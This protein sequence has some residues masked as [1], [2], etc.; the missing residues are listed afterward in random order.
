MAGNVVYLHGKPKEISQTTR[1]AFREH[2]LCEQLL[3]ANKLASRRFVLDAATEGTRRQKSLLRLLKDRQAEVILDTNCA[4]LSVV[5]R[6][7]GSASSAPW[8]A[9]GRV[10]ESADFIAGTNRSVIEPIARYV[11]NNEIT[12]VLSPSHFLGDN[13]HNWFKTDL[14]ACE[15][16]RKVLD[17]YGGG[18]IPIDYPLIASYAQFRDPKFRKAV[19][20]ELR[21]LPVDRVWLRIAGFGVGATGEGVSRYVEGALDFHELRVPLIADCVGGLASLA[22]SAIGGVSG[23][24]S[25]LE[26]KQ[27]FDTSDWL[28]SVP[29]KGGGG[30]SKRIFV[31]GLDRSL[32]ITEARQLFE[33]ARPSRHML[34]CSDPQC[35]GDIEKMLGKPEAH[36]AVQTGKFVKSLSEIRESLRAEQFVE[37]FLFERFKTAER[38][39]RIRNMNATTRKKIAASAKRLELA[40]DSL[41]GLLDRLGIIQFPSEAHFRG[42]LRQADLFQ[43][44]LI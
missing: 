35:C 15:D 36:Q 14:R 40:Y 41:S 30:G 13:G 27:R 37:K 21:N 38:A 9:E 44:G 24:A 12:A 23:F 16:L 7:S 8:S 4:E 17:Q 43:E 42:G 25:G 20:N 34:G 6:F 19:C 11:I 18:F 32:S 22:V 29:R 3:G 33:D 31:H 1:V 26:S 39:N 2:V 10:L 5:G 28:K